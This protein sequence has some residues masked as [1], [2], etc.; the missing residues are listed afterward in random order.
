MDAGLE[1]EPVDALQHDLV[2]GGVDMLPMGFEANRKTLGRIIEY[3]LEQGLGYLRL[4][5]LPA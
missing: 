4:S 3:A 1:A 2:A 5:G